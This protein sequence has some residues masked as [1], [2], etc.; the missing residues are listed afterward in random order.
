MC[1]PASHYYLRRQ[2]RNEN[3]LAQS[4]EI[5]VLEPPMITTLVAHVMTSMEK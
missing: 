4:A 5:T 3:S 2:C 1:Q